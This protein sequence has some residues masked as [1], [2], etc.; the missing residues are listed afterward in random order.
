MT[1]TCTRKI[2]FDAGHRIV[3]H[4]N[5][6]KFLHGH[7]YIIEATFQA[8]QIDSVGRVIDFGVI[9]EKLGSWVMQNLDHTLILWDQDAELANSV[10]NIT[11]QKIYLL[12]TNPTA[13]NIAAHL[14]ND[15]CPMLFDKTQVW[16]VKI[17]LHESENNYAEV[18]QS[19]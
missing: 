16:C 2:I 11:G 13:E 17:K 12:K 10:Q 4:E 15:I 7:R 9:K 19:V 18:V 8:K 5:S 1:I 6:C 14:L 3:S